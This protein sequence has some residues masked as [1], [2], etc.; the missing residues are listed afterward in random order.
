MWKMKTPIARAEAKPR[1]AAQWAF[2]RKNA[3]APRRTTMGSAA[4]RVEKKAL[5]NGLYICCQ[6]INT[7]PFEFQSAFE[8]SLSKS[9]WK[10]RRSKI[11]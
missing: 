8:P 7:P 5:F 2:I 11:S 6:G 1:M 4:K 10:M 3:S 9:S